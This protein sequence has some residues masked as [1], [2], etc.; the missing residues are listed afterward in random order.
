MTCQE[1]RD[2]MLLY[3]TGA[4]DAA[5]RAE[6]T[7][8]LA[9]GCPACA[10]ALAEA[11]ATVAHLPLAAD[12]VTPPRSARDKLMSR[13]AAD[14]SQDSLAAGRPRRRWMSMALAACI[15][16]ILAGGAVWITLQKQIGVIRSPD[17]QL[18]SMSSEVQPKARGR[19]LWDRDRN[20]WHI[21]VFDMTPPPPGRVYELWFVTPKGETIPGPTFNVD[22][23]GRGNLIAA[24]PKGIGPLAAAAITD[25]PIGGV[26]KPTGQKQLVGLIK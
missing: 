3:A 15:G 2:L 18:V 5:E 25:E 26:L 17:L 7:A 6:L 14:V 12:P 10:G 21:S 19:V 1:R 11:Q 4:L 8:H 24:V 22:S 20:N 16:A 9:G 23:S 13:V